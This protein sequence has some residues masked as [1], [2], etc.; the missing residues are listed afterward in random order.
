MILKITVYDTEYETGERTG[1]PIR[2]LTPDTTEFAYDGCHKV[3]LIFTP[4]DREKMVELGYGESDIFPVSELPRVWD[5]T[6]SLRFISPADLVGPN[7]VDQ[8]ESAD[9]TYARQPIGN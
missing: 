3:Y 2:T 8:C 5:E 4:E 6:C 1:S 7:F 9:V